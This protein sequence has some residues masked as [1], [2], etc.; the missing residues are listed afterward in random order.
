MALQFSLAHLTVLTCPPTEMIRIAQRTGY[1]FVSL[2]LT[3]VTP[4]EHVF[5]L[6][7]DRAM[8]NEVKAL[9]ADTGVGVLDIELARM[10][11]EIEPETYAAVLDTAAELGAR[12]ILTQLPDPDRERAAQRFARLC[13]MARPLGLTVD[14][15][16]PSWTETPD[17][18]AAVEVVRAINRPNAGIVIDTLHFN[19]SRDSINELRALPREW[20]HY[21]QV[22]D[23]PAEIPDTVEGLIHAARS[24]RYVPGE[25]GIDIRSILDAMP[26]LPYSLEIPNDAQLQAL[27]HEEWARRCIDGAR[28]YLAA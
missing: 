18:Q 2:R 24:E 15:E 4:T 5:A 28:R 11:A 22:C 8:L 20:F 13:D 19:R 27:G 6:Q 25:G 26:A 7:N 1:D 21:A 10:P 16:Y 9:L 23:A 17:L 3:A 14:V 12:H